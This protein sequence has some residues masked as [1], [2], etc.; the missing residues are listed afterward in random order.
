MEF[1]PNH[2]NPKFMQKLCKKI[3]KVFE[4]GGARLEEEHLKQIREKEGNMEKGING[5]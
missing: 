5:S 4:L 2:I 3:K 1:S